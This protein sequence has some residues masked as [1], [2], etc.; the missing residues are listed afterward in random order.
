[1]MT[2]V[3]NRTWVLVP[4]SRQDVVSRV[5]CWFNKGQSP[6]IGISALTSTQCY[7]TVGW[8]HSLPAPIIAKGSHMGTGTNLE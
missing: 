4:E 7:D 2:T 8:A 1:M 6:V 5:S 3:L